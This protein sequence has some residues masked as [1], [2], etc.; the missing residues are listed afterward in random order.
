M[1]EIS[2]L[3]YIADPQ[4][5]ELYYMNDAGRRTFQVGAIHPGLKCYQV[6]Q[7]L[8]APCSFCT[9]DRLDCKQ[10]YTWTYT[11]P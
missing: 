11:N 7:G 6:L 4:T 8:D 1:N 10:Y 2:E 5:Y 3:V 9:N